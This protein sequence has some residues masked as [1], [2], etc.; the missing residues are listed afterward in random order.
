M[1]E[2]HKTKKAEKNNAT[3]VQDKILKVHTQISTIT[4][5]TNRYKT[6]YTLPKAFLS[7]HTN[8]NYNIKNQQIQNSLNIAEGFL[9]KKSFEM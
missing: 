9:K 3:L 5:K 7:S 4:T 2:H 8:I 6:R 1:H